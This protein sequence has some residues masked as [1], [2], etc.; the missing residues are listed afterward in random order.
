MAKLVVA[1]SNFVDSEKTVRVFL[2][3]FYSLAASSASTSSSPLIS[4]LTLITYFSRV[5]YSVCPSLT[6]CIY[7][8]R[9]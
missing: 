4:P 5:H 3:F 1:F 2:V 7:S 9:D 8:E 6:K